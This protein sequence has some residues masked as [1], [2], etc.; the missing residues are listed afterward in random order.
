MLAFSGAFHGRTLS[1]DGTP[2]QQ[3]RAIQAVAAVAITADVY[4]VPF[5]SRIEGI[6]VEDTLRTLDALVLL[7]SG[8]AEAARAGRHHR[9]GAGRRRI[10]RCA[11]RAHASAARCRDEHGILLVADE[12]QSGMGRTGR[13]FA[14]EHSGIEPDLTGRREV[15]RRRAFRSRR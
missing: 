8:S 5:P 7:G 15:A 6:A 11:C 2:D 4:R 10:Q 3:I 9:A 12:I 13:L 14:I 1:D